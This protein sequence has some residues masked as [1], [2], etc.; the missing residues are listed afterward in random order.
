MAKSLFHFSSHQ[1]LVKRMVMVVKL[2]CIFPKLERNPKPLSYCL[3]NNPSGRCPQLA[4]L[5][6][7]FAHLLPQN[8]NS[9]AV[10]MNSVDFLDRVPV[11]SI[12]NRVLDRRPANLHYIK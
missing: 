9:R 10:E 12:L 8:S 11:F 1:I 6:W 2:T 4:L 3:S 7:F 5:S